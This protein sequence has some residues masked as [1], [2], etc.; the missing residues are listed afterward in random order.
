MPGTL[1][2][3]VVVGGG[4]AGIAAACDLAD[5]GLPVTLVE[6]RPVLGGKTWS[7]RDEQ[8][9]LPVD[10]G[11]H[12]F[13]GCCAAY[14][15][16]L[17]RLGI[18]KATSLQ[19]RLRVPIFAA[20]Y[21]RAALQAASIPLPAPLHLLPSFLRLPMLSWRE[22][23]QAARTLAA[24]ASAGTPGRLAYDHLSFADWLRARGESERSIK[25]LWNLITL[26]TLNE[27]CEWASAGLALMVFQEGLLR[28]AGGARIGYAT[29]GLSDLLC[30][31]AAR[32]LQERGTSLRLGS[33]AVALEMADDR[34][35]GVRLVNG[36]VLPASRVVLALPHYALTA[37]APAACHS[38]PFFARTA[39]LGVSPIV[40]VNLWLD[41]VVTREPLAAVIGREETYWVFDKGAL[42]NLRLA[43]Q[44]LTLSISGARRYLD[45]SREQIIAQVR[46]DLEAVFP[47]LRAAQITHALVIKER[48]A[49]FAATP[50]SLAHRLPTKTPVP[51]L[52]LA[53]AWTD[54][55]WPATMEG[56]V[57]SGQAAAQA[58]LQTASARK[59][60][61]PPPMP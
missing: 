42:L 41:R 35:T 22:K 46:R 38:Y 33:R 24:I 1:A 16:F 60:A 51:G 27:D 28:H 61:M 32:Y 13:L 6:A 50:G 10:N 30:E 53:G 55:G 31:A 52:Y 57:L 40:G 39:R 9:G 18:D 21:G 59:R 47:A 23:L 45:Q 58:I 44:Y 15:R 8:T 17:Q 37:L 7:F 54:T 34:L 5:A 43:G 56:A 25:Y 49:T 14:R 3:I 20:E 12:V 11:Q 36:E 19:P 26:P 29:V 4:L 2:D 48:Q